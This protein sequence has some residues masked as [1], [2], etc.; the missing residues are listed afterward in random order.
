MTNSVPIPLDDESKARGAEGDRN[1]EAADERDG[2]SRRAG[3]G[4]RRDA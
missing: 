2:S 3:R 4:R 1:G